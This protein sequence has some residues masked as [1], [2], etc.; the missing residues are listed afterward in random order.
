MKKQHAAKADLKANFGIYAKSFYKINIMQNLVALRYRQPLLSEASNSMLIGVV[1]SITLILWICVRPEEKVS[2]FP[3]PS[4]SQ[5]T[6]NYSSIC[7][8]SS[9]CRYVT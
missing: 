5:Q 9:E 6:G 8:N 7:A 2:H 3:S 1:G 4:P